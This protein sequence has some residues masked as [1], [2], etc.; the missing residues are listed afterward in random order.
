VTKDCHAFTIYGG[1]PARPIGERSRDL[2]EFERQVRQ[3]EVPIGIS[4]A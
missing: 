1:V 2:L 4:P 3:Q